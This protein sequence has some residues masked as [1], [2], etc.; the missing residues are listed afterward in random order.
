[1]VKSYA[2][3]ITLMPVTSPVFVASGEA[4]GAHPFGYYKKSFQ[5]SDLNCRTVGSGSR[6]KNKFMMR[7]Q[8]P[9]SSPG[10]FQSKDTLLR[11]V[12]LGC[13]MAHGIDQAPQQP[14]GV[15]IAV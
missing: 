1:M 13:R 4:C 6:G 9:G 11:Q 10:L 3:E 5:M 2:K 12:V 8:S 15:F 14:M 7:K